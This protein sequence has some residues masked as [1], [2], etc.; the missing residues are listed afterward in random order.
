MKITI[1][2]ENGMQMTLK[3]EN[4]TLADNGSESV[5]IT[6]TDTSIIPLFIFPTV[7]LATKE[8]VDARPKATAAP[9]AIPPQT[10]AEVAAIAEAEAAAAKG[11]LT[12]QPGL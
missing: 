7:R 10:D 1:D 11:R 4:L 9:A 5:I 6:K 3:P 8:E 12:P 2:F